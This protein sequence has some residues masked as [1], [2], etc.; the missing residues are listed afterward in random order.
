MFA[1]RISATVKSGALE[2]LVG[3][4]EDVGTTEVEQQLGFMGGIL[5]SNT[6]SNEVAML[7]FWDTEAEMMA[8]EDTDEF[9]QRIAAVAHLLTSP[10]KIEHFD[11]GIRFGKIFDG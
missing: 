9:I 5:M 2:E 3:F 11:V 10:R 7:T 6:Q 1:R 8:T 4:V